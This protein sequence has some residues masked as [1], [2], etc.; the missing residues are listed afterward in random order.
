MINK[1][2][3]QRYSL[4]LLFNICGLFIA[5]LCCAACNS[6]SK[7][8]KEKA[9]SVNNFYDSLNN[10]KAGRGDREVSSPDA[11]FAVE[12]ADGGMAEVELAQLALQKTVNSGVKEFASMMI[13]DHSKAN[14]EL[15]DIARA[16]RVALPATLGKEEREIKL[17]LS[18]KNR[19]DFDRAYV[20]AMVADHQ[21]D[22]KAFQDARK[23]VHYPEMA[24]FIDKTLPVLKMH[25]DTI[26]KL[27]ANLK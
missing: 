6:G 9:D 11:K 7:D 24:T 3:T 2:K 25:Y 22:I 20:E 17:Q 27:R 14:E 10:K 4:S 13:K 21:K 18:S 19:S 8:S 15:K 23:V 5:V 1:I 16:K 26:V 12:A